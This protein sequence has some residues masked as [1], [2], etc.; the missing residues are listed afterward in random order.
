MEK[1]SKILEAKWFHIAIIIVGT[2]FILISAF[3]TQI[4]YDEAYTMALID[5]NYSDIIEIDSKD[6]HPVL[7][8]LMLKTVTLVFGNSIVVARLFSVVATVLISVIGYT[9]IRKDFGAKVGVAF[10]FFNFFLPFMGNYSIEIRMY[11]WTILFVTL[12]GIYAY[13]T[14]KNNSIKNWLLFALFSLLGAHCHYYGLVAVGI[15]NALLFFYILF[16]KKEDKKSY[17]I[18]FAISAVIEIIGYLPWLII[19]LNQAKSVSQ[20]Y[21]ITFSLEETVFQP[22]GV[23]FWGNLEQPIAI[24]LTVTVYAY[25]IYQIICRIKQKKSNTIIWFCLAVHFIIYFLMLI[26]SVTIKPI[27]YHRYMTVTSGIL[28]FPI[29]YCLAESKTKLQKVISA[30]LVIIILG[31]STY[32]NIIKTEAN[33]AQS[34]QEIIEYLEKQ[35]QDDTIIL[36]SD[37]YHGTSLAVQTPEYNW[38]IYR[39]E[40]NENIKPFERIKT[41]ENE[42]F[43]NN[44]KGRII[45]VDHDGELYQELGEK[46]QLKQTEQKKMNIGYRNLWYQ[47][48]IVEK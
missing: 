39:M 47:L 32:D 46:Y 43:L 14:T 28:I 38:Y 30:L 12:A 45:I 21:W 4:W 31:F 34:N 11:T 13:R 16:T 24:T 10:T 2:I 15:I 8:Y 33:Y 25:L 36:Y 3:H 26:I 48:T 17:L 19:F 20:G 1:I 42:E 41:T 22:L 7:Y 18:H 6:V 27:L 9:H 35:Y 37:I 5:H 23:Q 40:P 29:A 44:Y